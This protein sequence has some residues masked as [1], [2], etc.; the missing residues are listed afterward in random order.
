MEEAKNEEQIVTIT[1][2][3]S[4]KIAGKVRIVDPEGKL[5]METDKC[6]FCRCGL[7]KKQPWCDNTHREF[8][9]TGEL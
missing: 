6:S 1:V 2:S 5:I 7:S 4:L 8:G 9:W 3:K